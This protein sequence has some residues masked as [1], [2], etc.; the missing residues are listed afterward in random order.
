MRGDESTEYRYACIDNKGNTS[1]RGKPA[2]DITGKNKAGVKVVTM[3]TENNMGSK[4]HESR[5]GGQN[6]RGEYDIATGNG[7]GVADEVSAYRAQYS[8]DG[9]LI[10]RD[11]PSDATLLDRVKKGQN[12]TTVEINNINDINDINAKM[13]N[14]IV[15]PGFI[16][17]YPPSNI[18]LNI[19]NSN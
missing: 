3:F 1:S 2:I 13:V 8:W 14:S 19:W 15:D 7:Y 10:Y 17:I 5:H 4:L 6:V 12:A 16:L 11:S 18:P 9:K